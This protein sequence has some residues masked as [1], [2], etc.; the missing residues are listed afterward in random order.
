MSVCLLFVCPSTAQAPRDDSPQWG[1]WSWSCREP[2]GRRADSQCWRRR[3]R[4]D[5]LSTPATSAGNPTQS[6]SASPSSWGRPRS[7]GGAGSNSETLRTAQQQPPHPWLCPPWRPAGQQTLT[8]VWSETG[9]AHSGHQRW[10]LLERIFIWQ[11]LQVQ[12]RMR[13]EIWEVNPL[14]GR[15]H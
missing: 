7:G 12:E 4:C 8:P 9:T 6:P 5:V 14:L 15:S 2:A 3:R 1:G 13:E 10:G 11:M